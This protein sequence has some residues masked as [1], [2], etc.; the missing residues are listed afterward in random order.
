[1]CT[2][3]DVE[4]PPEEI[5]EIAFRIAGGRIPTDHAWALRTAVVKAL[6]WMENETA[7]GI[8]PIHG[9]SSGNGWERPD[10]APGQWL[11]LPRRTSLR[12]R[13]P[14]RCVHA[15]KVLCGH[16]LDLD[17]TGLDIGEA[18]VHP[19]TACPTLFARHLLDEDST[20][21]GAKDA[22]DDAG[23]E[24]RF[25]VRFRSSIEAFVRGSP[26]L[27]CGRRN[28]IKTPIGALATRSL[29]IADLET[30]ASIAIRRY[31]FQENTLLGC[32]LFIPHKSIDAITNSMGER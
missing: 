32:G 21:T 15:A 25:I 12:L 10:N 1:M 22:D 20:A 27:I 29:L 2:D 9:A 13:I 17:A 11:F 4:R 18:R 8:H 7:A 6:P 16:R 31:G 23:D 28:R 30:D 14:A 5:V 19:L 26:R 3:P 24:E